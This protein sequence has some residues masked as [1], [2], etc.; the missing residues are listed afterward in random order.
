MAKLTSYQNA[1]NI[2]AKNE[3]GISTD[4]SDT[5]NYFKPKY[6]GA[7]KKFIATRYGL[8][9][10]DYITKNKIKISDKATFDAEVKKFNK[11]TKDNVN[12]HFKKHYWDAN[13]LDDIK[14]DKLAANIYDAMI[15][16]TYTL[17]GAGKHV[18]LARTLNRLGYGDNAKFTN[19]EA[20]DALNKAIDEKGADV[21]NDA[22]SLTREDSYSRSGTYS[23]HGKGWLKRLNQFRTDKFKIDLDKWTKNV[24]LKTLRTNSTDYTTQFA[25]TASEQQESEERQDVADNTTNEV[26]VTEDTNQEETRTTRNLKGSKESKQKPEDLIVKNESML[27]NVYR[28]YDEKTQKYTKIISSY[29]ADTKTWTHEAQDSEGLYTQ[30]EINEIGTMYTTLGGDTP[31]GE[32]SFFKE[33]EFADG[34]KYY[35][36]YFDEGLTTQS[37]FQ[38]RFSFVDNKPAQLNTDPKVLE[39]YSQIE[40]EKNIQKNKESL[41]EADLDSKADDELFNIADSK[42]QENLS[43]INAKISDK[44]QEI[45]KL[46]KQILVNP[47]ASGVDNLKER[48][49]N[50]NQ[51]IKSLNNLVEGGLEKKYYLDEQIKLEKRVEY[52]EKQLETPSS[53]RVESPFGIRNEIRNAKNK[54]KRFNKKNKEFLPSSLEERNDLINYYNTLEDKENLNLSISKEKQKDN[55]TVLTQQENILRQQLAEMQENPELFSKDE[56]KKVQLQID[57]LSIDIGNASGQPRRVGPFGNTAEQVKDVIITDS[58][59]EV[60]SIGE[61]VDK[62]NVNLFSDVKTTDVQTVPGE[63]VEEEDKIPTTIDEVVIEGDIEG[64]VKEQEDI[65]DIQDK[66]I[67]T[68]QSLERGLGGATAII[69]GILGAAAMRKA[70]KPLEKDDLPQLSDAFLDYLEKNRELADRGFSVAEEA[71]AMRDINASYKLGVENLIRG[72]AG[73]RAR[74][75]AMSG[76]VDANRSRALLDFA[77]KDAQMNRINLQN[78]GKVLTYKEEHD[79][80]NK[81]TLRTEKIQ[82]QLRDKASAATFASEAFENMLDEIQYQRQYG[83]GSINHTIKERRLIDMYGVDAN[84]NPVD[85]GILLTDEEKDLQDKQKNNTRNDNALN[86]AGGDANAANQIIDEENQIDELNNEINDNNATDYE[87]TGGENTIITNP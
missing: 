34:Q 17:G 87:N 19:K 43:K 36:A 84:G 5:G 56:I 39:K 72:T 7:Q 10:Y 86:D 78:Y 40:A 58:D 4:K 3:G 65:K 37:D 68:L 82:E 20:I 83:P 27:D 50:L 76:Q 32:N 13:N 25:L 35:K 29:N 8:T 53:L 22:Y 6:A 44:K 52:L 15:N 46:E 45:E 66:S 55:L 23:K 80:K 77:A 54:L 9:F 67:S 74:F 75:L 62:P 42:I 85:G 70:T 51:E 48:V 31:G 1:E 24:D 33:E 64:D 61:E 21:V 41:E 81:M 69:S 60:K 47:K 38:K 26:E 49:E 79:V 30:D 14:D 12:S 57:K 2:V 59:L 11:Y 18:T 73:D 71:K 63:Y 28:V 16:Q